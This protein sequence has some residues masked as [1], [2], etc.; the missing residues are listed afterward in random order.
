MGRMVL[1]LEGAADATAVDAAKMETRAWLLK[2]LMIPPSAL[3]I[4]AKVVSA[5]KI[6]AMASILMDQATMEAEAHIVALMNQLR[7]AVQQ[8]PASVTIRIGQFTLQEL[9]GP[10]S[11][12]VHNPQHSGQR[13][14]EPSSLI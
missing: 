1:R 11:T 5:R 13:R 9:S 2:V 4:E 8:A 7:L 14:K 6:V 3:T 10:D 12:V